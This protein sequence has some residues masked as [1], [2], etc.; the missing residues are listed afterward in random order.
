MSDAAPR[1]PWPGNFRLYVV[2]PASGANHNP[3]VTLGDLGLI[4]SRA[5]QT[6]I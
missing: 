5:I 3:G 1:Q 4:G 6:A 2:K